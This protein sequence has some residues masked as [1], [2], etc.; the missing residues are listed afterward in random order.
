MLSGDANDDGVVDAADIFYIVNY[1]YLHGPAPAITGGRSATNSVSAAFTGRIVLGD[2]VR[3]GDHY[4][5]PV[6]LE[7]PEGGEMPQAMALRV[8]FSGGEVRNASLH[9]A[10]GMQPAFEISRN[11][12]DSIAY[13]VAF[14]KPL[15]S[16]IVAQLEI[17]APDGEVRVEVDKAV[18]LL[19]DG[20][21][22][23]K[24]TVESGTLR[25]QGTSIGGDDHR[26]REQK[27][28]Q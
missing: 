6:S 5:I 13:L 25:V 16:G 8:V 28:N 1:L 7:L 24:A 20:S 9:R 17:A 4:V 10:A 15:T 3:N 23:R 22:S 19:T 21:G 11:T 14:D 12:P 26:G 27:E 18:T 2:A